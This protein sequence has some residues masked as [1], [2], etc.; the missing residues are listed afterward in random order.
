LL[1]TRWGLARH[2]WVTVKLVLDPADLLKLS[3]GGGEGLLGVGD[4]ALIQP[5]T[6]LRLILELVRSGLDRCCHV[7]SEH[8]DPVIT[9]QT[10]AHDEL[11]ITPVRLPLDSVN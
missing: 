4:L 11:R 5:R 8:V 7:R 2:W 3:Q 1:G 6:E 9:T 10:T